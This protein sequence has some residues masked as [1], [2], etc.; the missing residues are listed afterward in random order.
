MNTFHFH[1]YEYEYISF[2]SIQI[3]ILFEKFSNTFMNTF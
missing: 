2:K 3:Q 1:E